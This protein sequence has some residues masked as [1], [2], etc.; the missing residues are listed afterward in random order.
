MNYDNPPLKVTEGVHH[1]TFYSH[2]LQH[3]I[4]YNIYL[5]P[6]YYQGASRY[7]VVYHLHGYKGNESSE[8]S[9]LENL[10]KSRSAITVFVNVVSTEPD[11]FQSLIQIESSLLEELIPL[12]DRLFHTSP[13]RENRTLSG[14]SMGGNMAFYY[15]I[16]NPELFG[17]VV[18]YAPTFHHLYHKEYRTVGVKPDKFNEMYEAMIHEKWY[19]EKDNILCLLREQADKVR[20]TL[21]IELHIGSFDIL[22]CENEMMHRFLD[23]L[24]IP[25]QYVVF[26][27]VD[28]SLKDIL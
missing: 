24:S 21:Q 27:G 7:P 12:I 19:L 13:N 5:P 23:S 28:H 20:K 8:T 22:L 2:I 26:D 9:P 25:H 14:F 6:D 15:A 1:K 16:K 11:Y 17:G 10:I 18:S 3:E 4:G